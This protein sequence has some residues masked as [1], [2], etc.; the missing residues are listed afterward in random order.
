MT[1][2]QKQQ[3]VSALSGLSQK[4]VAELLQIHGPNELPQ[5]IARNFLAT[6][7]EILTEPMLLLLLFA[8]M[9]YLLVG[10]LAEGILLFFFAVFSIALILYQARR[11]ENSLA[12]LRALGA[13]NATAIRDGLEIVIPAS[14]IVPG[15]IIKIDEGERIPA[16][17]DLLRGQ[18]LSVDESLLTGESVAVRKLPKLEIDRT[19]I[20]LVRATEDIEV[21]DPDQ[22]F[23]STLVV[24]GYGLMKATATGSKTRTGMIGT[25]LSAIVVEKT[26]LESSTM[27]L[28]RIFGILSLFVCGALV[29]WYGLEKGDW[30]Q[31]MLSG[32][33]LAMAMLP[34]EFPVALTVFLAIGAWRLSKIK[35]LA[36]RPAVLE[37]LGTATV[38]CVDK[39][40]TLT[41]NH[42]RARLLSVDGNRHDLADSN[43]PMDTPFRMLVAYAWLAARHGNIDPIDQAV[44][45]LARDTASED[46][47]IYRE[48]PVSREYG[49]TPELL[50]FS[51]VWKKAKNE[52]LVAAK[53]A[54]EAIAD[55]CQ[56]SIVKR[57]KLLAEVEA[58]AKQGLRVL[59]V[60]IAECKNIDLPEK[61]SGFNYKFSGLISFEDPVRQTVPAA[62]AEAR[63]AGI[64]VKMITGDYPATA[65]AIANQS[66]IDIGDGIFTGPEFRKLTTSGSD[67]QVLQTSVFARMMPEQKLAL[68]TALKANHEIVAMTGD[69]V[70]DAPALK[71]A[72]IGIAMGQRGTDVAREASDIVLMNEDFGTIVN[73]IH[74][75]RRIFEN[76]R[77]VIIYISAIHIPIA[78]LAVLPLLAGMPPLL[79]PAHVVLTEM[80]IDPMASIAFETTPEEKDIMKHP[81]R[82]ISDQVAGFP[83]IALGLIQGTLLLA[84]CLFLYGYH[85]R[86][87]SDTE[88]ARTLAFVAMTAG[89]ITLVRI[90]ASREFV[91]LNLLAPGYRLFWFIALMAC[92]VL[93]ISIL[94]PS[95]RDLLG[96]SVPAWFDLLLAIT[97]GLGSVLVFDLLKKLEIVQNIMGRVSN[98]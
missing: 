43:A 20:T 51:Q 93:A 23:S 46:L 21:E 73:S 19:Q 87:G 79:L 97:A 11:S 1:T 30:V 4:Q 90:N 16:D 38:L 50:A 67:K 80:I 78:G 92:S 13:P 62:V 84:S 85:L 58:L 53:G 57:R 37:T 17:G 72:H 36:R 61:Q 9:I 54:P 28:V 68:V 26:R 33:A 27:R 63:A 32:V 15:D 91:L 89:N 48:W 39:T 96:F 34:E 74:M 41:E 56:L 88:T 31:G 94:T 83:Q 18:G 65:K 76:L 98:A 52:Y 77:K 64:K 5:D 82:P 71:A 8:A 7:K 86:N 2:Y 55:L 22:L 81:P 14:E 45:L 49:I 75:G 35:V 66:G 44:D 10:D 24:S 47:A 70:N 60:A 42:M 29:V 95:L 6:T 12:A 59:G 40:G 3:Q 25:S 69:G